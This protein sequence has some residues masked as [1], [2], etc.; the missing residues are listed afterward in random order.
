MVTHISTPEE[1]KSW[2]IENDHSEILAAIERHEQGD[3]ETFAEAMQL[4]VIILS[5]NE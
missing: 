5:E 4:A 1:I 2:A 3:L